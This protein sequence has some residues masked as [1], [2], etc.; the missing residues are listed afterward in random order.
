M[1]IEI[2]LGL[3]FATLVLG[4]I[5]LVLLYFW[6]IGRNFRFVTSLWAFIGFVISFAYIGVKIGAFFNPILKDTS[7][8]ADWGPDHVY[9]L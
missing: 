5:F 8:V 9:N 2:S 7:I 6:S 4:V 3:T 1:S